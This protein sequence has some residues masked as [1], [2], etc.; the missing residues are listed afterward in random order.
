MCV[1]VCTLYLE[2]FYLKNGCTRYTPKSPTWDFHGFSLKNQPAIGVAP[3]AR[4]T[5]YFSKEGG[6]E[7]IGESVPSELLESLP[8][9]IR[10]ALAERQARAML[11]HVKH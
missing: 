2:V 5:T 10:T 1:C 11:S 8:P 6:S 9:E 3:V 4:S 7:G